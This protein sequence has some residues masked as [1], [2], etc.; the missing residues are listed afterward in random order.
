MSVSES[1]NKC[2]YVD[3]MRILHVWSL[4]VVTYFFTPVTPHEET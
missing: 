3:E 4:V 1:V 2:K